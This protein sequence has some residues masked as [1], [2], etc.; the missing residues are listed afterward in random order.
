LIKQLGFKTAI[1]NFVADFLRRQLFSTNDQIEDADGNVNEA[2]VA[3]FNALFSVL[4]F[5]V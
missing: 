1:V 5:S 4:F 2:R 3:K